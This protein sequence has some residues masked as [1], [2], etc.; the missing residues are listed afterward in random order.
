MI[1]GARRLGR[2]LALDLAAHGAD[3]AV[4]ARAGG[5]RGRRQLRRPSA[6]WGGAAVAVTGD[7]AAPPQAAAPGRAPPPSALGGL[8]AL[9]YAASGPF[10]PPRPRSIDR[11]DWDGSFDVDRPG[12]LLHRLRGAGRDSSPAGARAAAGAARRRRRATRGVIVALT[13]CWARSRRPPSPAHGAAKAAQIISW[14]RWPRRGRPTACASAAS[15]PGPVDLPDDPRREATLRAA[16]QSATERARRAG[17]DRARRPLLHRERRADRRQPAGRR[18][19]AARSD[20]LGR[21]PRRRAGALRPALLRAAC[22]R[23]A[24]TGR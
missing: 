15:R 22:L 24:S 8:D 12:L 16:A 14:S 13:D 23:L 5:G 3:V 17:R 4:S 2:A 18:R 11:A 6:A 20:V 7:V 10:G 21:R 9:V 1:G 19:L